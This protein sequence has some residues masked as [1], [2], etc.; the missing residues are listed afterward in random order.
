MAGAYGPVHVKGREKQNKSSR[1]VQRRVKCGGGWSSGICP[2]P[3]TLRHCVKDSIQGVP[4]GC[5]WELLYADDL[6]FSTESME[7]LL[8]K[9][10]KWK[11][12]MDKKGLRGTWV[13]L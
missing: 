13:R 4:A 6:M 2:E 12:E 10:K 9:L 5:L 11:S 7:E 8:V 1:W 3:A